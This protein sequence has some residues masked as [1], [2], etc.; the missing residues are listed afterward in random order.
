MHNQ[1]P[2]DRARFVNRTFSRIAKHYD[3]MNRLMT[4]GMDQHWRREVI[5]MATPP[6]NGR[7]L[8]LGTGTGDLARVAA[9]QYPGVSM[10]A[11]DFTREMM[12]TKSDWHG[13]QR[14]VADALELPFSNESFDSVISGFLMRNVVSVEQGLQEQYRV[15]KPGGRIIIL[16]TTRP[17]RN[18]F[19]PMV[20][21]YLSKLIPL[22]GSLLTG[23]REAY[24]YL[25][26][27]TQNFLEAED[28]AARME[29]AGFLSVSFKI[30]MFGTI[31]IHCGTKA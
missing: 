28:L 31:A 6:S 19:S 12:T 11:A 7:L 20:N 15:L 30:K 18:L 22:L 14:A 9:R 29:S 3:L 25:P 1:P 17:R 27:S 4:G 23:D 24:T 8:D 10:V 16:D 21:V 2:T 13:I 26:E 5:R